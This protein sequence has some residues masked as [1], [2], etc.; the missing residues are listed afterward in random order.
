MKSNFNNIKTFK[1]LDMIKSNFNNITRRTNQYKTSLVKVPYTVNIYCRIIYGAI[2]KR[3]H[4]QIVPRS[5][6]KLHTPKSLMSPLSQ[7]KRYHV[8]C[9]SLRR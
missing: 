6:I 4:F 5:M 7:P 8:R 3:L 9:R 2:K 1:Q